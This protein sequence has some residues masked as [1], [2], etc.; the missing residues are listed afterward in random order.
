M[1]WEVQGPRESPGYSEQISPGHYSISLCASTVSVASYKSLTLQQGQLL[2][3]SG[4]L[5]PEI[6]SRNIVIR[7]GFVACHQKSLLEC[8][9]LAW[10]AEADCYCCCQILNPRKSTRWGW[11]PGNRLA[12]GVLC[13]GQGGVSGR[14]RVE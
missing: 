1:S 11:L 14:H 9:G 13:V 5:T 2:P 7:V 10:A 4:L 3:T 8:T 6:C 12:T